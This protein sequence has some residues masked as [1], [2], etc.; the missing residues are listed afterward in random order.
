MNPMYWFFLRFAQLVAKACFSLEIIGRENLPA[1]AAGG[2][3]LAMNHQSYLD[4]PIVALA[5]DPAAHS[6]PRAQNPA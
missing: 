6:L 5:A 4:P 2:C 3:L 1:P